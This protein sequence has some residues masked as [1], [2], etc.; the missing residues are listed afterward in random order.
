VVNL[1]GLPVFPYLSKA[2]MDRVTKTDA[3]GH[4]CSRFTAEWT[5]RKSRTSG[6]NPSMRATLRSPEL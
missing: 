3:L 2:V 1:T 6:L 4:W 5:G